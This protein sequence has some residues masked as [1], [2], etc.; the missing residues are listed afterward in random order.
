MRYETIVGLAVV[1]VAMAL[2]VSAQEHGAARAR[3]LPS[4]VLETA[5]ANALNAA[6]EALNQQKFDEASA[7]IAKLDASRLSPYERGKVEQIGFNIAYAA[8]H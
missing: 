5:T 8:A 2:P 1:L 7:T 3:A 4:P 6:I